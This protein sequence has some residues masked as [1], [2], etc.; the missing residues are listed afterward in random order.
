MKYFIPPFNVIETHVR[1][2]GQIIDY[3]YNLMKVAEA[4][5]SGEKAVVYVVDTAEKFIASDLPTEGNKFGFNAT[6]QTGDSGNHGHLVAGMI[7]AKNNTSGV[8]GISPDTMIIPIKALHVNSGNDSWIIKA[9]DYIKNHYVNN[10]KGKKIGIINMSFGSSSGYQPLYNKIKECVEVGLIPVAAAGNDG[11]ST[12]YPGAWDDICI[13]VAALDKGLN[14]PAWTNKG[15][16][17]DIASFGVN[18]ISTAPNNTYPRV[19]GTS[20]ASPLISGFLAIVA[21]KHFDNLINAGS[22]TKDLLEAH[23]KK[24]AVDILS[25]GEDQY[26]AGYTILK[27][28][29]DNPI[30][31]APDNPEEPDYPEKEKRKLTFIFNDYKILWGDSFGIGINLIDLN[32]ENFTKSSKWMYINKL[33]ISLDSEKFTEQHYA[34]FKARLDKFFTNRG[35]VLFK[36][37]DINDAAYWTN[38]FLKL[39]LRDINF[40]I[41]SME[42]SDDIGT[43]LIWNDNNS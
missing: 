15:E 31:N 12:S 29:L 35:L 41:E 39:L 5:A 19:S 22:Q 10:F 18:V 9:L 27:P 43:K 16:A 40:N 33:I 4:E 30:D 1:A 6:G 23:T 3:W 32:K 26:G 2:Q 34:E 38:R 11:G 13:T 8:L 42:V 25:P 17:V 21:T 28:Y 20:F 37:S 7:A 36:D 24:Y 14:P